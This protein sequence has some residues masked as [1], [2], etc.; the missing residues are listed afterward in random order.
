MTRF[1]SLP[2]ALLVAAFLAAPALAQKAD[3]EKITLNFVNADIQSVIK[4]VGQHTGKNFILDPRVQGTVSAR[5]A[6]SAAAEL[7]NRVTFLGFLFD[8]TGIL[9]PKR[10]L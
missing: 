4:T 8:L 2:G 3:D 5:A 7:R 6:R 1:L 9:R 10:K